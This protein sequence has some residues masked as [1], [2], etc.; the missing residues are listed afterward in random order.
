MAKLV[1]Y[2]LN[3]SEFELKLG[4]YFHFENTFGKNLFPPMG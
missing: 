1:D 4:Y 2:D 3:I